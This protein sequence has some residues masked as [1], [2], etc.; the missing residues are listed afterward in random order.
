MLIDEH[1][2]K[3][4][5]LRSVRSFAR[6]KGRI[7]QR[8]ASALQ[9][10]SSLWR[11]NLQPGE[12]INF[13]TL[14]NRNAP[15][16]LEIGFGNGDVL[17]HM[18]RQ[19]PEANFIGVEVYEAGIGNTLAVIEEEQLTT[20]RLINEDA[21][22]ILR[23]H[24][25]PGTLAGIHLFFPDPWP[26]NRHHKRRLV[27]PEFLDLV[28][29]VLQ[30]NGYIHMATDW[31]PYAEHMLVTLMQEP[32]LQNHAANGGYIDRPTTRPIT[33]FEARGHR[34]GHN[35]WDLLFMKPI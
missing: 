5:P 30:P 26:K 13:T 18:A 7:T 33:K 11:I 4:L 17:L 25:A 12:V 32:R 21:V 28:V 35:V 34:L 29:R 9:K 15:C 1:P 3:Q 24:I 23:D 22:L 16:F 8:Q 20:I 14:F 2:D 6:R 10:A 31:Q 27:Q 19:H